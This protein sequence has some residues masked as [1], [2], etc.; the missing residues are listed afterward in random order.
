MEKALRDCCRSIRI[1]KILIDFDERTSKPCILYSRFP[2][3]L[4]ARKILLLYPIMVTGQSVIAA[5]RTLLKKGAKESNI[6][7]VNL[8]STP[9]GKS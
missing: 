9:K 3:N 2:P 7:V 8:F 1:G 6:I 4:Q 5:I